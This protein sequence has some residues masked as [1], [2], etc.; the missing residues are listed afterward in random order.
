[1]DRVFDWK[2]AWSKIFAHTTLTINILHPFTRVSSYATDISTNNSK[3]KVVSSLK[4]AYSSKGVS[5]LD[6][7]GKVEFLKPFHST[8]QS[9]KSKKQKWLI[10][11]PFHSLLTHRRQCISQGVPIPVCRHSEWL[12]HT[13]VWGR[14]PQSVFLSFCIDGPSLNST[15]TDQKTEKS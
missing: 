2:W 3:T 15:S 7:D 11:G 9:H 13:T 5:I 8:L 14:V 10:F 12:S 6:V 1:M 4:K